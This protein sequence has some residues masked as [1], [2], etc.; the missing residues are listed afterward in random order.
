MDIS[1]PRWSQQ[2]KLVVSLLILALSLYLLYRF[3]II[4][5]PLILAFIIAYI[6][7]PLANYFQ[8]KLKVRRI[9]STVLAF[10][11]FY[12]I[13][14][15]LP[16]TFVPMLASQ[17]A[18]LNVDMQIVMENIETAIGHDYVIAGQ[19]I[20]GEAAFK[21]VIE[22]L[23]GLLEPFFASTMS[24]A[25]DVISSFVWVI[26]IAVVSFYLVKDAPIFR[27]WTEN[28]IPT[29][30]RPVFIHLRDEINRIWAAFFRGQL[31]LAVVVMIIF[32]VSGFILGLAFWLAMAVFAGLL[33]F[34]PSVGHGIW[35]VT[36]SLIALFAGSTWL[37]V[38]N[39]LFALIII[40]LHLFFQQFDLNYLI[41]RII[42]HSVHLPPLVVILGIVSGAVLAGFLGISLAAPTIASGRILA[43]YIYS[44]I[45]DLDPVSEEVA[46][47]LPPPNLK[48]WQSQSQKVDQAK[49][50]GM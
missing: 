49:K 46:S 16:V 8:K 19:I 33:E 34:L 47:P 29:P 28:H 50:G 1:H 14:A 6:L 42:G 48:W 44:N 2:T 20:D 21:Q 35:L 39:W 43:R 37:P 26:F 5:I 38:P 45:F 30:Y 36:A 17:F 15:L 3:R 12:L 10:L 18:G 13:L 27:V 25:V 24:L 41:P 7:N 32:A 23:N 31:V 9:L 22:A 11:I 4:L 40:A